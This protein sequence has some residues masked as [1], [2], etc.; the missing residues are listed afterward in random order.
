MSYRYSLM[1][2]IFSIFLIFSILTM[3]FAC[4][5]THD[6]HAAHMHEHGKMSDQDCQGVDLQ[7]PQQADISKPNLTNGLHLDYVHTNEQ[8]VWTPALASNSGNRGPP[9]GADPP[10]TTPSILLTTQRLRI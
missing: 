4:C 1:K 3:G 6:A 5:C 2:K 10:N 8:P 9:A 7:L